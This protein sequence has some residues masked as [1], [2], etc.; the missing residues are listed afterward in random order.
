[1]SRSLNKV[2]LIGNLG[3]DPEIRTTPNG[4]KV[5]QFS[6]ATGRQ[7]T[8]A[9]GEKQEKTEWHKCVAWNAKGR[10]T[11]LADVIERY[12]KKGDKLYVEGE[13]QY[14]QYEDKDKQ[15]RYVTEINVREI[16]LLGGGKGGD[17]GFESARPA[18]AASGKGG[19]AGFSDFPEAM[20]GDD[21][22]PF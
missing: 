21:D 19:D 1:M 16:L 13:I 9:S 15:T 8:S 4:S 14:R 11:G 22:L 3:A 18:K 17:G 7:W 20:D 6:L 5:A 2:T 12:V 10:G